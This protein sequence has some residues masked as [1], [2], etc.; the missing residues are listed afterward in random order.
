MKM[1][2]LLTIIAAVFAATTLAKA[3]VDTIDA[4]KASYN[5]K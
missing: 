4:Q 5:K 1:Y 2:L 3:G